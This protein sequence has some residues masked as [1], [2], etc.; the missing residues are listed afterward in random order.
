VIASYSQPL[1]PTTAAYIVTSVTY[2]QQLQP[3]ATFII[4]YWFQV[5][6]ISTNLNIK[7]GEKIVSE[8]RED[9]SNC[10]SSLC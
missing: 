5:S 7:Y 9:Y 4:L 3:P 6:G 10:S 8:K 2:N 1:Q